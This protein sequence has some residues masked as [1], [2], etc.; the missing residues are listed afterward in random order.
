MGYGSRQPIDFNLLFEVSQ[1]CVLIFP[2]FIPIKF[3]KEILSRC[4]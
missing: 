1:I 4:K 3:N 2:G